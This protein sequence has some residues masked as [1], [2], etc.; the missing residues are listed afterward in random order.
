MEKC[1]IDGKG[2][3]MVEGI[4]FSQDVDKWLEFL[5]E[6]EDENDIMKSL[7]ELAKEK[8]INVKIDDKEV[9]CEEY[10]LIMTDRM[11]CNDSCINFI[12]NKISE[13]F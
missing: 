7:L 4:D 8:Y 3:E 10:E 2:Y 5:A 9:S 12:S 1:Y 6:L 13:D 11:A